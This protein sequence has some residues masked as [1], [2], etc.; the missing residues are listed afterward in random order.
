MTEYNS[1]GIEYETL[2]YRGKQF[3]L[4]QFPKEGFHI[5]PQADLNRIPLPAA[6]HTIVADLNTV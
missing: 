2:G 1:H 4:P 5:T 3:V 6:D